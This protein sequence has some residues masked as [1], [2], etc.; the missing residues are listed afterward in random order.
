[1]TPKRPTILAVLTSLL[2]LTFV[3]GA[4]AGVIG[5]RVVAGKQELRI[6][7]GAGDMSATLDRLALTPDQRVRAD[8]IV[9]HS[10]PRTHAILI[11]TAERLRIVADSVDREL[12]GILSA[13][14]R[15][16][17]DSLRVGPRLML[18]RKAVTPNATTVDTLFDSNAPKQQSP[19]RQEVDKLLQAMTTAFK[20]SPESVAK[21]YTDDAKILGGGQRAEGRAQIDVYWRNATMFADW[22]LEVLEVGGDSAT[23]WV[24]GRSTLHGKS[25]R[26][27]VTEFVGLLKRGPDGLKF[28]VDMFVAAAT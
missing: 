12:R 1:M 20:S 19:L 9:A 13:E 7:T 22:K 5:D 16:R 25:G 26:V 28:Y 2:G 27:M 6:R 14:Q 15:T 3:A 23:P 8:S 24:R 4:S 10:A 18:K 17:L 11:E 21:F